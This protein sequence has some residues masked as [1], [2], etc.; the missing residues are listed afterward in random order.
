MLQSL[1]FEVSATDPLTFAGVPALLGRYV[2]GDFC[3]G[4]VRSFIPGLGG[5][6]SGQAGI[7]LDQRRR[8]EA[9]AKRL[10]GIIAEGKQP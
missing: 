9:I 1:L 4:K 7:G 5:A 2:Y 8:H 6:R 3:V 10:A